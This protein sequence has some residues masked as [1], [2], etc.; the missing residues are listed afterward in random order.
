M[1]YP[2]HTP[3]LRRLA[4]PESTSLLVLVLVPLTLRLK[5]TT[6]KS[7]YRTALGTASCGAE[8]IDLGAGAKESR[9]GIS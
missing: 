1:N 8:V 7:R 3:C 4:K 5:A 9:H 2:N 6:L